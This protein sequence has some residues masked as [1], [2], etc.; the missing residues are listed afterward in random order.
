MD[1]G[2]MRAST[3]NYSQPSKQHNRVVLSYDGYSSYLLIID[4]ASRYI[5]VFLTTSKEPPLDIIDAFLSRFGHKHGGSIRTDQGGKLARLLGLSDAVLRT[6]RYVME[7]TGADSPLQ[8]GAVE[9]YND[10]L[11]VRAR[12]LLYGAGLPAKFWSAALL[13]S[14]YLHNRMVHTVV[15]KTPYEGYYGIKPDISHLKLFGSRVCVKRSGNRR[16]KLDKHDFKGIF[17]GYTA[18]DHNILYLDLD[19]GIVK[20]SHHAQ[21]DEA[22]YLQATRPPASQLLYDLGV[23][24][25]GSLYSNTGVIATATDSDFHLPGTIEQVQVAWPPMASPSMM[26]EHWHVP[27]K[28]TI[29]PLPF[30]HMDTVSTSQNSITAKRL[31]RS[32]PQANHVDPV[33]HGSL[34]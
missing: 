26:K 4:K 33:S 30:H 2:F 20:H 16:S 13:H 27:D 28:C 34:M 32:L 3:S 10:K 5:W 24:P 14:V 15:K 29:L 21:F 9:I 12:T 22:W 19:S 25:D 11:A 17:L 7:P 31:L 23:E 8:N 1:F 18:T 6:H